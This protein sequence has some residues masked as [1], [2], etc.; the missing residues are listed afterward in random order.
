MVADIP[1]KPSTR[2]YIGICLG[3]TSRTL[4]TPLPCKCELLGQGAGNLFTVTRPNPA[5]FPD[6][7]QLIQSS[8]PSIIR[9][10]RAQSQPISKDSLLLESFSAWGDLSSSL[11]WTGSLDWQF[12]VCL[13]SLHPASDSCHS[14]ERD[15]VEAG[16]EI[17]GGIALR[18]GAYLATELS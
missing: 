9:I 16:E 13:S 17:Q 6:V 15:F 7:Q 11:L 10:V 8:F 1:P 12:I 3:L 18:L 14:F 2:R 4:K 5:A